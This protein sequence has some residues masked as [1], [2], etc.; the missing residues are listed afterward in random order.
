V[1]S[2]AQRDLQDIA[3]ALSLAAL[4]CSGPAHEWAR[5]SLGGVGALEHE[6]QEAGCTVIPRRA[7][8][9]WDRNVTT[10]S[11]EI[12]LP[13][14]LLGH[15]LRCTV[16]I[17]APAIREPSPLQASTE[18]RLAR[19]EAVAARLEA[20][21]HVPPSL[22]PAVVCIGVALPLAPA[23]FPSRPVV[24]FGGAPL[25]VLALGSGWL[26]D[27]RGLIATC[28]H[29][30]RSCRSLLSA[31]GGKLIV[32]P[33]VAGALDW[34]AHAWRAIV[35]AHTCHW[36]GSVA[37]TAE[38][39]PV[40][41]ATISLPDTTDVAVLWVREHLDTGVAVSSPLVMPTATPTTQ[42]QPLELG[43]PA[44]LGATQRLFAL[45]YPS[46]GGDTPTHTACEFGGFVSDS[47]SRWLKL[48]G[49][50]SEGHSG[51]PIVAQLGDATAPG[52]VVGWCVRSPLSDRYAAGLCHARPIDEARA[53]LAAALA[54]PA[55]PPS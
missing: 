43:D 28:E 19:L 1:K 27:V 53:C 6:V 37:T 49:L 32:C 12:H 16:I 11:Q 8:Q 41:T 48:I 52:A 54:H 26:L 51:G 13:R 4:C 40:G 50:V 31:H 14:L 23:A 9:L 44:A 55:L 3:A 15:E 45:G 10:S 25:V 20:W 5:L 46:I 36:D 39:E 18:A 35:L 17:E 30:R 33:H 21:T 34:Q 29:V 42:I 22:L 47:N 2:E 24:V 38:T 7:N